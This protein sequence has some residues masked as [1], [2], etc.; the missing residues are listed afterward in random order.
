[1]QQCV[2]SEE[3]QLV[4]SNVRL[5]TPEQFLQF[6]QSDALAKRIVELF[7]GDNTDLIGIIALVYPNLIG[8]TLYKQLFRP[9]D[10]PQLNEY[11]GQFKEHPLD[12]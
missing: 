12:L 10:F 2:A 5:T 8:K 7:G 4:D 11:L 9:Y 6:V 1:M 3:V